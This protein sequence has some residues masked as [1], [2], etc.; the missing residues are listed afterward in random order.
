MT[1]VL[2]VGVLE[3]VCSREDSILNISIG[4]LKFLSVSKFY[5]SFSMKV[6]AGSFSDTKKPNREW[7]L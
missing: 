4:R 2:N 6:Q 3:F 1:G 5:C 7:T